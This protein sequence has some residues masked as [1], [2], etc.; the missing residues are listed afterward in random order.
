MPQRHRNG[1]KVEL[2]AFFNLAQMGWQV[3][4]VPWT[5]PPGR[6]LSALFITLDIAAAIYH[7]SGATLGLKVVMTLKVMKETQNTRC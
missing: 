1:V 6:R 4:A 5:L 2:Q 7:L 3:N